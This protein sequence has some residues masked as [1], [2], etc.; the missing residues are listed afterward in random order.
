[1]PEKQEMRRSV[2][3]SNRRRLRLPYRRTLKI[4]RVHGSVVVIQIGCSDMV[5]ALFYRRSQDFSQLVVDWSWV[6]DIP[7]FMLFKNWQQ[8]TP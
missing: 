2:H 3:G 1:M 4:L 5:T 8:G 7:V 6:T